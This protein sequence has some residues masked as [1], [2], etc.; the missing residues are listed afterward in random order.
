MELFF[1]IWFFSAVIGMVGC[2]FITA[3]KEKVTNSPVWIKAVFCLTLPPIV[4]VA[5]AVLSLGYLLKN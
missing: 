3:S 2:V 5:W 4:N 1:W